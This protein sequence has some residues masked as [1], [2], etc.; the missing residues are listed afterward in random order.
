MKVS[1]IFL[2]Q[3]NSQILTFFHFS[4]EK[5]HILDSASRSRFPTPQHSRQAESN[6][7]E[8]FNIKKERERERERRK[9]EGKRREYNEKE[10][11]KENEKEEE[12]EKEARGKQ[13]TSNEVCAGYAPTRQTTNQRERK[14]EHG[15]EKDDKERERKNIDTIVTDII[16]R[17]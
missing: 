11:K 8:S 2:E 16:G 15:R 17:I 10:E 13:K 3:T 9:K 12:K 5:K 14:K 6:F 4:D 1:K 7:Y